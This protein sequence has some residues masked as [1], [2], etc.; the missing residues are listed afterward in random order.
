[1]AARQV[2]A[3]V[4]V[5]LASTLPAAEAGVL[6]RRP[7]AWRV[8]SIDLNNQ[9][10]APAGPS[11]FSAAIPVPMPP[12]TPVPVA[13]PPSVVAVG[14]VTGFGASRPLVIGA[15]EREVAPLWEPPATV[16]EAPTAGRFAVAI[17]VVESGPPS[18]VDA[19]VN[20]G[21]GNF[22]D[23]D[24]LINGSIRPWYTSPTAAR[25]FGGEPD[26]NQRQAFTAAVLDRVE[27]TFTQ[28][29]LA[30]SLTAD[31]NA[32][33][34]HTL[35]VVSGARYAPNPDAIGIANIGGSGFAFLDKFDGVQSVDQLQWALAHNVAHE[36]M[37]AFGGSHHDTTG[38][39]LD[40]AASPWSV[41]TDP[42]T[43]FS[44]DAV[45]ELSRLDF[46]STLSPLGLHGAHHTHDAHCA[47]Q[48]PLGTATHA[49]PEPA[50]VAIWGLA[51]LLLA[52][53]R[54]RRV[55]AGRRPA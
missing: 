22:A 14:P 1:M 7:R 41:L 49:V 9:A 53:L 20:F 42:N 33:A 15:I 16:I 27:Q 48:V 54:Y 3:V 46:R 43:V 30:V 52:G 44:P 21:D 55:R 37:H 45:A 36:L 12:P 23:A 31:P 13:V 18:M 10:I 5:V 51:G 8:W 4:A 17:P 32:P 2:L 19:V 24:S 34:A 47:C 40:A 26:P 38:L 39:Y 6:S 50:T 25:V 35:S 29:G 28:S 11:T